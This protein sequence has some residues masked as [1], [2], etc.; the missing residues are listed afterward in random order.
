MDIQY[1]LDNMM[2][3]NDKWTPDKC[4]DQI[5]IYYMFQLEI[6]QEQFLTFRSSTDHLALY[7]MQLCPAN[8]C[9]VPGPQ[10]RQE[11]T[12]DSRLSDDWQ[13]ELVSCPLGVDSLHYQVTENCKDC[14]F[15]LRSTYYLYRTTWPAYSTTCSRLTQ[16]PSHLAVLS[17]PRVFPSSR[18]PVTD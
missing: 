7:K 5:I 1:I 11:P 14:S 13:V 12:G 8:D 16:L 3:K 4:I 15:V 9:Q 10:Y 2:R 17:L 6:P 18:P